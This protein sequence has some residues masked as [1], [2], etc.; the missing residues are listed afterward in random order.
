MKR[1]LGVVAALVAVL[2][3]G[4]LIGTA[5]PRAVGQAQPAGATAGPRYTVVETDI[6]SLL[7]VDNQTNTVFFY[8]T[9]QNAEPGADLHL[10]GSL[11]LAD[12]GKPV[13]KPQ[14]AAK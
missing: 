12:V 9:E 8:T 2:V 5:T 3:A 6:L 11:N 7:V 14:K 1:N 13:L 4:Y 10:R